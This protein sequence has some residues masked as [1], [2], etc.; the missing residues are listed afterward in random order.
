MIKLRSSSAKGEHCCQSFKV[1]SFQFII[2]I[3]S[4]KSDYCPCTP[5]CWL[6]AFRITEKGS[7]L[8]DP[9]HIDKIFEHI[10]N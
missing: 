1:S 6:T 7:C 3:G 5:G 2:Y 10:Y 9:V 8:G 4:S